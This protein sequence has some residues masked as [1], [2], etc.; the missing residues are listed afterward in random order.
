MFITYNLIK[1]YNLVMSRD[2]RV[3]AGKWISGPLNI[4]D[5]V[6]CCTLFCVCAP[7]VNL[8][9]LVFLMQRSG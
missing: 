5:T 3:E 9:Y 7:L 1:T 2:R 6:V 8:V 4:N